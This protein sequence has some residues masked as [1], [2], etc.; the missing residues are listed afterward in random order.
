MILPAE[1]SN[2]KAGG[3]GKGCEFCLAKYH[4]HTHTFFL[5]EGVLLIFIAFKNLLPSAGFEPATLGSS[6]T[7]TNH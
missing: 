4:F 5:Q 7:H 2:S 1:S 3:T 6:G